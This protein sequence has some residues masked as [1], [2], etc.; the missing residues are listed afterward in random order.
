MFNG[1]RLKRI[2]ILA[3]GFFVWFTFAAV[4]QFPQT[5]TPDKFED[6][7][8]QGIERYEAGDYEKSI[9]LLRQYIA[10][11]GI[12]RLKRA[13][14]YYY[15]AKNYYAV[16]PDKVKD[17]LL[18]SLETDW[19][20]TIQEKDSYFKKVSEDTRR[21]FME[22]IPV[23]SYL[24]QAEN[25]FEQGE[26]EEAGYRYRVIREK[27]PG[28]TFDRQIEKCADA[29]ARRQETLALYRENKYERAYALL[30]E[31]AALSPGDNEVKAA[32]DRVETQKIHP[33]IEA[34][35]KYF[36]DKNYREAV[37]FYEQVL[38]FMPDNREFLDKLAACRDRLGE[39]KVKVTKG[40]GETIAKEGI[41]EQKKKKKFPF[42]IVILGG[43]VV[44][45]VLYFILKKKKE[46]APKTGS[47]KVESTP[48]SAQV[49]VDGTDT[50]KTT[51]TVLTNIPP[52]SHTIKLVKQGYLDYQ[53]VLTV[54]AGKE[55]VLFATLTPAPTPNFV[56]NTDTVT[57]PEG[58]Q[59][60][61]QVKLSEQPAANVTAA[62]AWVSGDTDITLVSGASLV[63][64]TA[65]WN[66]YQTVTLAAAE[67]N[68][69]ENGQ[70][71][72]RI[73]AA[74]I[75]DKD[76]IAVEQ[77]SG[78]SGTLTVSP[79]TDF[80]ASGAAGGPFTPTSQT[81]ILQNIGTSS[82][83]WT[84]SKNAAWLSLSGTE[85][86]LTG[87]TST[88]VVV[89]LNENTNT[90]APGTYTDTVLLINATNG[91]GSTSRT[92]TL[93]V[94]APPDNPPAVIIK[95]P[96]NGETVSGTVTIQVDALDDRGI[97]NVEIYIDD[98]LAAALTSSP[99]TY[100]WDTT[101]AAN[102]LHTIKAVAY[103]TANQTADYQVSVTVN[104]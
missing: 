93:N 37:P 69:A 6:K 65:N 45:A 78:G 72:F 58:G 21:E 99:Y 70:A 9:A 36:N 47:I 100:Q 50:G 31:L 23:D 15:L 28:K 104:N 84:A 92:V 102:G 10:E 97:N 24:E 96:Q 77:D 43:V 49:R 51:P 46:P 26:Y 42:L 88:T 63:F 62:V 16:D 67:D 30:K 3:L 71:I 81:Y 56:T 25:A 39:G 17:F 57:V 1:I 59:N 2:T 73:S 101:L 74:G 68:D 38:A 83:N 32:I 89:F 33:M 27:L 40:T 13:K 52:G 8:K 95:N 55:T 82:I 94:T 98:S 18:K 19:F 44:A 61:F 76:I 35:D 86:R 48:T 64:T 34:G 20:F 41:P 22:K 29:Q 7:L 79:T 60:T 4:Y 54:E 90:L 66:T 75:P 5:Q 12:P 53:V 80:S 91:N 11:P 87:S 85:G 103:D 14:T